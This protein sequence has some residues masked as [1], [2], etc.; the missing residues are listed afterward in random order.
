MAARG[1][2]QRRGRVEHLHLREV[3]EHGVPRLLVRGDVLVERGA[4]H[5]ALHVGTG[6]GHAGAPQATARIEVQHRQVIHQDHFAAGSQQLFDSLAHGRHHRLAV[7]IFG[8]QLDGGGHDHGLDAGRLQRQLEHHRGGLLV[9]IVAVGQAQERH[10][11][12]EEPQVFS[13]RAVVAG[14]PGHQVIGVAVADQE[15]G[16]VADRLVEQAVFIQR[17]E[18]VALLAGGRVGLVLDDHQVFL[19]QGVDGHAGALRPALAR[20][21]AGSHRHQR[22][23]G[24]RQ[25]HYLDAPAAGAAQGPLDQAVR[26][27]GQQHRRQHGAHAHPGRRQARLDNAGKRQQRPVPQVQRVADQPEPHGHAVRQQQA[28]AQRLRP[29]RDQQGGAQHRQQRPAAGKVAVGAQQGQRRHQQQHPGHRSDIARPRAARIEQRGPFAGAIVT[30][31]T[32]TDE[33]LDTVHRQVGQYGAEQHFPHPAGWRI[34]GRAGKLV[35]AG[36]VDRERQHQHHQR[37]LEH[38]NTAPP[39]TPHQHG[40]DNVELLLDAERPQVQQRLGFGCRVEIAHLAPEEEV[41]DETGA[42]Q[43]VLAQHLVFIGE[44]GK[45]AEQHGGAQHQE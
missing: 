3:L 22:Q 18:T 33:Q 30:G 19:L 38:A 26:Q 43:H 15:H 11:S 16:R 17:V 23:H 39:R 12:T 45:P 25:H 44:Q 28:I 27:P 41:R 40:P 32:R 24:P 8:V 7:G 9:R 20:D 14:H 21:D 10:A 6:T 1:V 13:L 36:Q 29:R 5:G 34:E 2:A 31:L 35:D 42:G 4:R 37:Q